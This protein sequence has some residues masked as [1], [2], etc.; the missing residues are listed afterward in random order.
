MSELLQGDGEVFVPLSSCKESL[1]IEMGLALMK[2]V[3]I[4]NSTKK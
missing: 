3:F 2:V 1:V 4:P